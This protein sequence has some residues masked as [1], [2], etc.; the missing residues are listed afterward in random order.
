MCSLRRGCWTALVRRSDGLGEPGTGRPASSDDDSS[1]FL[2]LACRS[3]RSRAVFLP[4]AF[5]R[6]TSGDLLT[7]LCVV[8]ACEDAKLG[9][10]DGSCGGIERNVVSKSSA[11]GRR[12]AFTR[13]RSS[14]G[15]GRD[16]SSAGPMAI[17]PKARCCPTAV[18]AWRSSAGRSAISKLG[19]ARW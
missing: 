11:Q 5:L 18:H 12:R 7:L 9:G 17:R 1:L 14:C 13:S 10:A 2:R 6:A 4:R 15:H 3:G 16:C 19:S 8:G